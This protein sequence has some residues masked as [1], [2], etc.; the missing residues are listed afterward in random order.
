MRRDY[1]WFFLMWFTRGHLFV[2]VVVLVPNREPGAEQ[3]WYH[4]TRVVVMASPLGDEYSTF[5]SHRTWKTVTS[6]LNTQAKSRHNRQMMLFARKKIT[7]TRKT[8]L[9]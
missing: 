1:S 4:R 2:R 5:R 9:G 6:A 3:D 7:A 8:N